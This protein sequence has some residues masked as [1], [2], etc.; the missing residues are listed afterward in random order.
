MNIHELFIINHQESWVSDLEIDMTIYLTF[1]N[2]K[3]WFKKQEA[4]RP[5]SSAV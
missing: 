3:T 2:S 4:P 5:D 1:L